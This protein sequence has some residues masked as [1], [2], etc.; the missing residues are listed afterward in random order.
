M[1]V[2]ALSGQ[3]PFPGEAVRINPRNPNNPND[4]IGVTEFDRR[5]E[6]IDLI[7]Y[8]HPLISLIQRCLSNSPSHR[9]T[10]SEVHQRV[11]AVA[12]DH[13]PSFANRVDMM[14]RIKVLSDEKERVQIEKEAIRVEKDTAVR[15]IERLSAEAEELQS[16]TDRHHKYHLIEKE[17]LHAQLSH[18]KAENEHLVRVIGIKDE[19]VETVKS[20]NQSNVQVLDRKHR[21]ESEM[22]EQKYVVE[23]Q[24]LKQQIH[25]IE[26]KHAVQLAT[27]EDEQ[28]IKNEHHQAE[29]EAKTRELAVR[30]DYLA[31]KSNALET[32]ERQLEF[33]LDLSQN[34][35]IPNLF[36]PRANLVFSECANLPTTRGQGTAVVSGHIV[37]VGYGGTKFVYKYSITIDKWDSLPVALVEHFALDHL[38]GKILTIGGKMQSKGVISDIYEFD[39]A[40][41]QWIGSTSIPPIPTARELVTVVSWS[42]PPALIVCGGRGESGEPMSVVEIYTTAQWSTATPLPT[43]SSLMSQAIYGDTIFFMGGK[44]ESALGSCRKTVFYVSVAQLL[45]SCI[46]ELPSSQPRLDKLRELWHFLPDVPHYRCSAAFLNGCLLAIGGQKEALI[47]GPVYS[48]VYAYCP[49]SSSWLK[50]GDLPQPR[51]Y[52]TAVTLSTR[53]LL[54]IGGLSTNFLTTSTIYK[55]LLSFL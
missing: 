4:V 23:I 20:N 36:T 29:L 28:R 35:N 24:S 11:N 27:L 42:S 33:A 16:S 3:W 17:S 46:S 19:E 9:P 30:A 26:K 39:E 49:H 8:E 1:M 12:A 48:S 51:S 41:Q 25:I 55:C 53:E 38:N 47:G 32:L 40:S 44:E 13:P 21:T 34:H 52:T 6:Y 15:A 31:T 54:V 50:V 14:D 10:S 7:G 2:H 22:C 5:K 43:P 45:A 18:V 37:Y